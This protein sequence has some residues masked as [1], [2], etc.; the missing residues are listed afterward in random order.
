MTKRCYY[1]VLGLERTCGEDEIKKAYRKLALVGCV[2]TVAD[3]G[4]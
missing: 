1:E 4:Y 2:R 3:D